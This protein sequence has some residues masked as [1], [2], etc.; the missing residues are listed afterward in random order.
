MKIAR[1]FMA[2][3]LSGAE[4]EAGEQPKQVELID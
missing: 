2:G 3:L 1:P 4:I